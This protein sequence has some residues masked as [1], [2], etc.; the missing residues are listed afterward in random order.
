MCLRGDRK[1]GFRS[2]GGRGGG[3]PVVP[4]F[5]NPFAPGSSGVAGDVVQPHLCDEI[6]GGFGGV[7]RVAGGEPDEELPLLGVRF[8]QH[9]S[10]E[11]G[12]SRL[13]AVGEAAAAGAGSV[14][15]GDE[16]EGLFKRVQPGEVLRRDFGDEGEDE[17]REG[18]D[19]E[20][21]EDITEALDEWPL[22]R[23]RSDPLEQALQVFEL[24]G[25]EHGDAG[26]LRFGTRVGLAVS[27]FERHEG[28][29][30]GARDLVHIHGEGEPAGLVVLEDEVDIAQVRIDDSRIREGRAGG[31][32]GEASAVSELEGVDGKEK[33]E[34]ELVE[35]GALVGD[36]GARVI[37]ELGASEEFGPR[38]RALDHDGVAESGGGVE[39]SE[40]RIGREIAGDG[41]EAHGKGAR[42]GGGR[43]G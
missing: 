3:P 32:R 17:G 21:V 5:P 38:W 30:V 24:E 10:E 23:V 25:G 9:A 39:Q 2:G 33:I 7:G 37:R 31:A 40:V 43:G 1:R 34:T 28:G 15:D 35:E 18:A 27:G 16:G 19:G 11:G 42:I 29:G 41:A 13:G 26:V 4:R 14:A 22:G 36:R 6:I 20:E 8:S 12:L